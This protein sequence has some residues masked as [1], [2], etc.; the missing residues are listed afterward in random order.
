MTIA[1]RYILAILGLL[2]VS[3]ITGCGKQPV[4]R[5][6]TVQDDD[7]KMNAAIAKARETVLAQFVPALKSPKPTQSEFSVK[8]MFTENKKFE[9][10]W[11]ASVRFDGQKFHGKVSNDPNSV[12]TVKFGQNVSVAP[13]EISDWMYVENRKL[14]GG[15]T[16]RVLRDKMSPDERK[17]FDE[18]APFVVD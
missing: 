8:M 10:M 18:A 13:N 3:I 7:P 17:Q 15:F 12:K 4:D 16:I 11:L 2:L 9:H 6:I 1:G 14:K 5:V